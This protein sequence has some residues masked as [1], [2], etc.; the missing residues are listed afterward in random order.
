MIKHFSDWLYKISTG[1]V[2]LSGL[3]ILLLFMVFVL[4]GQ[5]T[6]SG[7]EDQEA[8][9]PD[10]SFYYSAEDLYNSAEVYGEEGRRSY[11]EARFTFDLVW[12]LVYTYF[13][14]TSI[15]WIFSRAF[16]PDTIW[17][18]ANLLPVAGMLFDYLENI[19]TSLVMIR[20]P[21]QTP[22]IDTLAA[23]FTMFKW[24]FI[25]ASFLLLIVGILAGIWEWYK[26][27]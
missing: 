8:I 15:S 12:P 27:R 17:R 26:R 13:L 6:R 3:I 5:T 11:V 20:Y 4:P 24:T 16:S 7:T 10:L 23:I 1:W 21:E 9:T 22:V 19:S 18:Y 14:T 25:A 2:A